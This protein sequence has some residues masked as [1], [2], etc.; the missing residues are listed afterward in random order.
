MNA[1]ITRRTALAGAL[2]T[3]GVSSVLESKTTAPGKS[4]N[5]VLVHGGWHGGW[6]WSRVAERLR[7]SGHVVFTPTLTGLG[8]RSHLLNE[9]IGLDTHVRDIA[10]VL[11]WEGLKDVVLVGHS[12]GGCVISGVAEHSAAAIASIVFLDAFVPESGEAVADLASQG[13]RD[14]IS[15]AR[16]RGE[17]SLAPV[18]AANFRVNEADRVWVDGKCTAHPLA[19]LTDKPTLT[20]AR[21][22]IARKTYIRA[23]GYPSTSFDA[24]FTRVRANSSWRTFEIACGHDAMIDMPDRL[25]EI[26]VTV[27]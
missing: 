17:R 4:H 20:G 19:T 3:M 25:A 11:Q 13:V 14:A 18:P 12:Y 24:A 16:S 2:T 5:F 26:L 15:A 27:A 7:K 1:T 9:R 6:C 22:R 21:D 8:E 10:N 23:T